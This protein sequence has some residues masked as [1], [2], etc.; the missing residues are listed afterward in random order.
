MDVRNRSSGL[1]VLWLEPLGED[2]W[3]Q[4]GERFRIRT[5]YQ[6]EELAFSVDMWIDTDD[7]AVGIENMA[8]WVEHGDCYAEV[9][10]RAGNTIECGHNRPP[11][12]DERWRRSRTTSG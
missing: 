5:D 6:G 3:L 7:R 4:P 12:I 10:D 8:V 1:L 9:T 2:R 11:E